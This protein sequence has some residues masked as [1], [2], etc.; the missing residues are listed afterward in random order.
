MCV[1]FFLPSPPSLP[2]Y[3]PPYL[4]LSPPSSTVFPLSLSLLLS[5]PP[6]SL[7]C[8]SLHLVL[9]HHLF[10][11]RERSV[12]RSRL[13]HLYH[14]GHLHVQLL[15]LPVLVCV[16]T[17]NGCHGLPRAMQSIW[18]KHRLTKA[19]FFTLASW[20]LLDALSSL[21]SCREIPEALCIYIIANATY[22]CM[23]QIS[24]LF[25]CQS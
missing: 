16:H 8:P 10:P 2:P 23:V 22:I 25:S 12:E 17:C 5:L 24:Y 21:S 14:T 13:C 15:G 20:A 6:P 19:S 4:P 11:T 1:S 18:P 7:P 3:L 9:S